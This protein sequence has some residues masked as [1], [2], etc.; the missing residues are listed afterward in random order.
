MEE[1]LPSASNTSQPGSQSSLAGGTNQPC[2]GDGK[3]SDSDV[4]AHLPDDW[5]TR[6]TQVDSLFHRALPSMATDMG[7]HCQAALLK[8]PGNPGASSASRP[9][10]LPHLMAK[11]RSHT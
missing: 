1:G 2:S 7:T 8:A 10:C 4:P 5:D 6:N 11:C 9:F 3:A